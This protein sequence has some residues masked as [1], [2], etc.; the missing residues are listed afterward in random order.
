MLN[1][2]ILDINWYELNNK[3]RCISYILNEN[4]E[5]SFES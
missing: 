4:N 1:N 2:E 3:N 5:F